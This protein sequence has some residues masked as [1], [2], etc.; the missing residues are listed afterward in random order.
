MI[1]FVR[2]RQEDA[3]ALA[4]ASWRAFDDDIHYGAPAVGGPPGYRSDRWQ[5]R[6]MRLG[7]YFKI[8]ADDRIIGGIIVFA[9]EPGHYELGRIFIEPE[10]QNR[11]I[12]SQAFE[13][14]WQTFPLARRWTLGT[15]AWNQRNHHFYEKQGFVRVGEEGPPGQP[16]GYLYEK[17]IVPGSI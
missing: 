10:S 6:M 2:A 16:E 1:R 12:G 8:L 11:G 17:R 13:F 4:M 15:P 14:L 3:K 9:K 5:S 7:R